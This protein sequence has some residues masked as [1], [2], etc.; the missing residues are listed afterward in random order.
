[1]TSITQTGLHRSQQAMCS[2]NLQRVHGGKVGGS[3]V[4]RMS[5]ALGD[6]TS[7][8]ILCH[9]RRVRWAATA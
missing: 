7:T 9:A 6:V 1:M 2:G 5:L 3:A 8:C 4:S